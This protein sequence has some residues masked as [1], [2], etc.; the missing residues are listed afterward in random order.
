MKVCLLL[1][2][3]Q[4]IYG[5]VIKSMSNLTYCDIDTSLCETMLTI[6]ALLTAPSAEVGF[7]TLD[8]ADITIYFENITVTY[9]TMPTISYQL[10]DGY[11]RSLVNGECGPESL[12]GVET[13]P[14]DDHPDA[15][16]PIHWFDE[17]RLIR[18]IEYPTGS[19]YRGC[20]ICVVQILDWPKVYQVYTGFT[21]QIDKVN[22]I[23][24]KK[25]L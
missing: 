3:I 2:I 16:L 11:I 22:F 25:A 9:V 20:V 18:N 1:I 6:N 10:K 24:K 21:S 5:S 13:S 4:I 17:W 14:C 8:Q 23:Y 7:K 15:R 19:S 12:K